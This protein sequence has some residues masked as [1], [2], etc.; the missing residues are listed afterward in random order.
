MVI[1]HVIILKQNIQKLGDTSKWQKC[2]CKSYLF[3][4]SVMSRN[5][6]EKWTR[7]YSSKD[8]PPWESTKPYRGLE[9]IVERSDCPLTPGSNVCEFGAGASASAE[10]LTEKGFHVTAIDICPLAKD[11]HKI[12]YPKSNVN[13]IVGDVLDLDGKGEVER[14]IKETVPNHYEKDLA[15]G[16][17]KNVSEEEGFYF[18]FIF[19]MQS[20]HVMRDV[21]EFGAIEKMFNWLKPGGYCMVVTGANAEH[22]ELTLEELAHV[23]GSVVEGFAPHTSH[24]TLAT[25]NT[26]ATSIR[27]HKM[28]TKGPPLLYKAE[29]VQP[30]VEY[31]FQCIS[32][33]LSNFNSTPAYLKMSSSESVKKNEQAAVA[34]SASGTTLRPGKGLAPLCWE[35]VFYKPAFSD[36]V[37]ELRR[38]V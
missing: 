22:S 25:H 30:F 37:S 24:T 31:G 17:D 5:E 15:S 3:Y 20:F 8:A 27:L 11:R 18:S 33:V 21:D 36:L 9:I 2:T 34:A 26:L 19:D 13:Y 6:I 35:A 10:Y 28:P 1:L 29:L 12:L 14:T 16:I 32:C 38:G 4:D 23:C 7:Y